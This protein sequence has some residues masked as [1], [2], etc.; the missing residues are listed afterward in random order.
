MHMEVLVAGDDVDAILLPFSAHLEVEPY[1][2]ILD[3][4]EVNEMAKSYG[5]PVTDPAALVSKMNDWR[6]E[7]G[8][9]K[10][11]KLGRISQRNPRAKL[12]WYQVG[13]QWADGLRLRN[14]RRVYRCFG[15]IP[16]GYKSTATSALKS[17]VDSEFLQ[18]NPPAALVYDGKWKAS[19]FFPNDEESKDWKE[20][21][22]RAFADV[23]DNCRLT[24]VDVHS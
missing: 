8:F 7:P 11:G 23:P 13:G 22:A 3:D 20:E 17:E 9:I 19:T 2:V 14:P 15:L 18:A 1:E 16:T 21:F 10:D 6:H 24:I 12:D 4:Y 5:V